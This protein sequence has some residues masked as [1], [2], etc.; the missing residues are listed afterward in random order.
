MGFLPSQSLNTPFSL[1]I[2]ITL[3][4]FISPTKPDTLESSKLALLY[5]Q[6]SL[7]ALH[8]QWNKTQQ[9]PCQWVGITCEGSHV[10]TLR[11]PGVG[12]SGEIPLGIFGNLTRL[13]T[14]SL[15]SNGLSGQLPEDLSMCGDLRN[16]YLQGN[17]LSGEIPQSVYG[18]KNLVRLNLASNNFSGAVL[19]DINEL[20][21]LKTLYLESNGF[22]G[23]I[24]EL[25][26]P[27]L[28]Q[29]NV[30]FNVFEGEIPAR[31]QGMEADSFLGEENL[32]CGGPLRV[33]PRGKNQGKKKLSG[34]AIAGIVIGSVIGFLVV[35]GL[36]FVLCRRKR[37]GGSRSA[38]I[39]PVKRPSE[40]E[41]PRGTRE[42]AKREIG[43][44]PVIVNRLA[45]FGNG[46]N[47]YFDLE[48]L[49]KASAEVLGNGRFGTGYKAV[50]DAGTVVAVKRLKNVSVP[51]KEFKEKIEVVGSMD[52]EH[53]VPLRAYYFSRD[54]KLLV[55]DYMPM[56]SLSALLHG[57]GFKDLHHLWFGSEVPPIVLIYFGAAYEHVGPTGSDHEKETAI[58]LEEKNQNGVNDDSENG[59]GQSQ[60]I[61]TPIEVSE[62]VSSLPLERCMRI[63]PHDQ[64]SGAF[65]VAVLKKLF[66]LP[67]VSEN[68]SNLNEC[69]NVRL[70]GKRLGTGRSALE[71]DSGERNRGSGRS[72]LNWETRCDI[73]LGAARGIAYLHSRGRNVS[74]G[75]IKSS[76]I[77][78]TISYKACVSDFCLAN[79]VGHSSTPNHAGGY[80][81]PEITDGRKVSQK[82]DIYSFG[83]VLLEL[84]TGKVP[85]DSSLDEEDIVDLPRW[86]ESVVNE[87]WT[88]EVFDLELLRYQNVEDEMVQL[89]QL[90]ISC[91]A[92]FPDKRPPMSEVVGRIEEIYL[93]SLKEEQQDQLP[94]DLD[95]ESSSLT[96]HL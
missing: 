82:A 76:N 31:V 65:F 36:V 94:D 4:C 85:I 71:L 93:S 41:L 50:L 34:G 5:F 96:N 73:A 95:D 84:L 28:V 15:R 57:G 81:A 58:I 70:M 43:N 13:R 66:D 89:L 67:V 14:V 24:P 32:L 79:I 86:V 46:A 39:A 47:R 69:S 52:H 64:G 21:R 87:D 92:Q 27:N 68:I 18:L 2:I 23:E 8:L 7:K 56:G 48:D 60:N 74:H 26:L 20:V 1:I 44:S 91:A 78:L 3:L 38:D 54:E 16:L 88:T 12:L 25:V 11:L 30:S 29:F 55:Y 53:I 80:R 62:K 63:V 19:R 17:K 83:V 90:A 40:G 49:L 75:N 72:P 9:T 35:L 61:A 22:S 42:K 59:S 45:F 33:C 77:L 51:E 6:T 10:I 37:S